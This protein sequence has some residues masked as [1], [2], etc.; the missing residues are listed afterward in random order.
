[1]GSLPNERYL[2]TTNARGSILLGPG[3]NDVAYSVKAAGGF[4]GNA[5]NLTNFPSSLLTVSA[6]NANYWRITTA[7]TGATA[8]G[9]SGQMA[10]SG[11]NLYIYSPNALGTGTA[12]WLRVS[13]DV[14]W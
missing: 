14:S 9:S 10:V 12:R 3:T 2:T 7:P 1:M 11:T 5:A 8:S 13:G 4:Y 6:G